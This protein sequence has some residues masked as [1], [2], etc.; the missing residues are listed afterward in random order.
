MRANPSKGKRKSSVKIPIRVGVF[1]KS[2]ACGMAVKS[3]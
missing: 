2:A 1:K 3:I